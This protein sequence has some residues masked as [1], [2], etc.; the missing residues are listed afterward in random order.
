MEELKQYIFEL[1][2]ELSLTDCQRVI[3]IIRQMIEESKIE[4]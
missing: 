4:N 1:I 2:C 3:R